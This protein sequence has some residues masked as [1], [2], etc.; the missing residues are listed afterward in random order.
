MHYR[1]TPDRRVWHLAIPLPLR[2]AVRL[3]QDASSIAISPDSRWVAYLAQGD[4]SRQLYLQKTDRSD[5][6][7]VAGAEGTRLPFFSTDAQWLGYLLDGKLMKVSVGGSNPGPPITIADFATIG[8]VERGMSWGPDGLILYNRGYNSGLSRISAEGGQPEVL[9]T[10]LR[11]QGEKTHRLPEVLP[12]GRAVLFTIGTEGS[13]SFDEASIAVLDLETREY[14]ILL[15]GG[16]H[17][18][19]SSTGHLVYARDGALWAVRFHQ[20]D[21]EV[22]GTPIPVVEGVFTS[23]T[24]GVANFDV[25]RDGTLVF[26]P[27]RPDMDANG[28]VVWVDRLGQS[29]S[30]IEAPAPYA[31]VMISPDGRFLAVDV[32]GANTTVWLYDIVR[33]T[34]RRLTFEFDNANP[35]W[36]PDEKRIAF[37]S[38]RTGPHNLFWQA[39]SASSPAEQLTTSDFEPDLGSWSPDAE[40]LICS[41]VRPETRDDLWVLNMTA[42]ERL[43]RFCKR[44]SMNVVQSSRRMGDGLPMIPM[45]RGKTSSTLAFPLS[46]ESGRSRPTADCRHAGTP[47]A[48]RFF[49]ATGTK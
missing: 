34:M 11:E 33:E 3:N 46:A 21:L 19:Y 29:Q 2:Q 14:R 10:R 16:I 49:T 7:P 13:S 48:E 4:E 27:G 41:E 8:R 31:R 17:P 35:I 26:A 42:I 38:S 18:R 15:E 22:K 25:S 37:R 45:S 36:T 6:Q 1:Q 20:N 24:Q 47:T 32:H 39:V 9:T 30:L 5:A 12:N 28:L 43:K 40:V 44:G 23:S